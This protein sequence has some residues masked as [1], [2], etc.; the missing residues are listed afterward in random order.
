MNLANI[1]KLVV[2]LVGSVVVIV[3]SIWGI[4]ISG[5]EQDLINAINTVVLVLTSFG[6]W[7][8]TNKPK[9]DPE[10]EGEIEIGRAHV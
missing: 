8:V 3:N 7:K 1:K 4:D 10:T 6:V 9:A 2:V 5:Q